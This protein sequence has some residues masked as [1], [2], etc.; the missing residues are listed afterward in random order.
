MHRS[1]SRMERN[2]P[3]ILQPVVGRPTN[4][5]QAT[6]FLISA[7]LKMQASDLHMGVNHTNVV[8]EPYLL[9]ARTFGKLQIINAPFLGAMYKEV[10]GRLKILA[11]LNTT[12][13]GTPQDGQINLM[14]PEGVIVLRI[15]I[16][17]GPDGD[18]I[19]IRI[20]KG[21][22]QKRNISTLGM[23]PELEAQLNQL[24]R[25]KSGMII[26]NGPG[27]S[28]KTSTIYS[29]LE[30][31]ASPERK[32][33]T[34]EDPIE[35][36]LPFVSHTQ[37]TSKTNFGALAKAF[38]RQDSDVIFIGEVRDSESAAAA[39]QLAQTGNLVFTTLHT[40][41]A[42]G[43]IPRLEAFDIHTNFIASSLI[44]SLSQRL[45]PQLCSGCKIAY[46]PDPATTAQLIQ[47]LR[48]PPQAT[49]FK[50]GPGCTKCIGGYAGRR[51]VFELFVVD[52]QLSDMINRK[53]S[54]QEIF[55]AARSTGFK[56]LSE[57]ILHNI[58]LG[59]TD[60][61]SVS[62]LLFSP[63]YDQAA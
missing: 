10:V 51:A 5:A 15:S 7:A 24:I 61:H 38:M 60:L 26:L 14:A 45:I 17:P 36:R 34:A 20:Q 59:Q 39:V 25:M 27:G 9:R 28:G 19:V 48:P 6:D 57:D 52:P 33:L 41:D 1:N 43:V 55:D 63:A 50:V 46:M 31:I 16:I 49:L 23:N 30:T 13:I 53:C 58:Y 18:E 42:I 12:E 22:S 2:Q 40:R 35:T 3:Y 8:P 47:I 44:G 54:R 11:G 37:V 62:G 4:A 56:T 32:V 21:Q 29:I